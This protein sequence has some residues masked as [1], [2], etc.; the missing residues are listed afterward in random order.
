VA[1][2][3]EPLSLRLALASAAILGGIAL[4]LRRARSNETGFR[5][6]IN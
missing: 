4:V 5:G 6:K 3:G 2:L 1:V